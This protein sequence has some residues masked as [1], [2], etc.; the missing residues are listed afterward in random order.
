[1][2]PVLLLTLVVGGYMTNKFNA[3]VV[4]EATDVV[5]VAR[6]V[7][8]QLSAAVQHPDEPQRVPTDDEMVWIR[9]MIEQDVNLY[10]GPALVATSQRDLFE[11]GLLPTRTPASAYRAIALSRLPSFVAQD[12]LGTFE[13]LIAAAPVPILRGDQGA[14]LT[15]P[16]ALRQR[17]IN[18]DL[19]ALNRGVMVGAMPP[20]S[21]R[22]NSINTSS[23]V[24]WS[25]ARV[26]SATVPNAMR[27]PRDRN[28]SRWHR[29]ASS[30]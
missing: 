28:A 10:Q 18:Y 8:E 15:V 26:T 3:D 4:T 23:I 27:W 17:E 19:Q 16:L 24:G 5:R 2:G 11:A 1:V 25:N 20:S 21:R 29:S 30:M 13:Y 9:Q 12:R 6:R 7:F 22:C 14:V